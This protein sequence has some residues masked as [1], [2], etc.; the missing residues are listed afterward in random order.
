MRPRPRRGR[1]RPDRSPAGRR[2]RCSVSQGPL[3]SLTLDPV[4]PGSKIHVLQPRGVGY[5]FEIATCAF[6]LRVT[7]AQCPKTRPMARNE[8]MG[9][10][11]DDHVIK[12]AARHAFQPP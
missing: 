1:T 6:G 12:H 8:E 2:Y 11:V 5:A 3:P 7:G 10:L 9:K 4:R